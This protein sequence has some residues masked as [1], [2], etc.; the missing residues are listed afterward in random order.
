MGRETLVLVA[1]MRVSRHNSPEDD[2]DNVMWN[3]FVSEVR[4]LAE[5]AGIEVD[6]EYQA[7]EG[8]E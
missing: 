8:W 6:A 2:Q 5:D 3:T 1:R 7:I 4:E